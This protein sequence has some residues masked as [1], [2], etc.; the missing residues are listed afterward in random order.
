MRPGR[1]GFR[2][3]IVGLAASAGVLLAGSAAWGKP[4][5]PSAGNCVT[6]YAVSNGF[7]G[8]LVAPAAAVEAAGLPTFGAEWVEIGWG[9]ARAYQAPRLTAGTAIR[10]VLTPG[11]ST[12]L[13]APLRDRPDRLWRKGVAAFGLSREGMATLL[14]EVA[15]EARRDEAGRLIVLSRARGGVFVAARTP[16]RLWRMCN[17][18]AAERLRGAG[19][20]LRPG[21]VFTAGALMSR[22]EALPDC[23][24]LAGA[25]G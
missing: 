4:P 15:G 3:R 25:S 18:W 2:G 12:L 8:G 20:T 21:P 6:A 17:G 1:R 5:P 9:E 13:I 24:E 16:F 14:R 11:P 10:S 22:I 23:A 19:V 7:H